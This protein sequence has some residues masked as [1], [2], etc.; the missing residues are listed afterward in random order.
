MGCLCFSDKTK[1]TKTDNNLNFTSVLNEKH[2]NEKYS[3]ENFKGD[4][5]II[6]QTQPNQKDSRVNT[7]TS[8]PYTNRVKSNKN[9]KAQGAKYPRGE[10]IFNIKM[11]SGNNNKNGDDSENLIQEVELFLSINDIQNISNYSIKV[12]ICNNKKLK[13]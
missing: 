10:K 1:K 12:W 11:D 13:Q 2:F 5:D 3:K 7:L 6:I 8:V 4:N 9:L